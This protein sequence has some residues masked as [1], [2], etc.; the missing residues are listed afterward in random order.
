MTA[1]EK[2]RRQ[3][4]WL[5]FLLVL[6]AL[7]V[8]WHYRG[9]RAPAAARSAGAPAGTSARP[10][11]Q[12]G[13][14]GRQDVP[15]TDVKLEALKQDDTDLP[16]AERNP[17]RFQQKAPPPAPARPASSAPPA[18]TYVPPQP[19]GPPPPPPIP[20]HFVGMLGDEAVLADARGTPIY[21]KQG[22]IVDG[23]YRLLRISAD[24]IDIAYA[25]GR[26][27]QTLPLTRQSSQ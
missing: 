27:R 9:G 16:A 3:L 22:D 7:L 4:S 21:G 15:V 12:A 20:L 19:Q 13:R 18:R 6:L 26:G 5:V 11:N 23:R 17:F 14:G 10:S 24:S 1:A 25:D 2:Q 8:A